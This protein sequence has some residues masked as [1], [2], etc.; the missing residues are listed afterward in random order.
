MSIAV[1]WTSFGPYH[2]ARLRAAAALAAR[3]GAK[4][5]GI[6][7]APRDAVYAWDAVGDN[8]DVA[9]TTLFPNRTYESLSRAEI[10]AAL[11]RTLDELEPDAVAVNGW[12]APEAQGA[13]AWS[14]RRCRA[15]VVMSETKADDM[16]R[17]WWKELAKRWLLGRCDAA[18]VGGAIHGDYL[19]EL[20]FPRERI[21]LGYDAVDNDYFRQRAAAVRARA[22]ELR[23]AAGLPPR[24]FFACTRFLARKNVDGLLRAYASY[25]RRAPAPTWGLVVAGSGEEAARLTGLERELALEGVI[26]RGFIQYDR[27]PL[28]Y[29]LA[30]AFVHAAKSEPWGLVVN[31]AIAS[32]LPVIVSLTTGARHDLVSDGENGYVFD[33]FDDD[34][35]AWALA[36]LAATSEADREA[37]GRRSLAIASRWGPERFAAG[38]IAAAR[39]G[40]RWDRARKAA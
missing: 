16:P 5:A 34:D 28:Y 17:I 35:L 1:I 38:L 39:M 6:E 20:G 19:T 26:W 13:I 3:E 23:E 32:G 12:S 11:F 24:F 31:E 29:G 9:R 21:V 10:A 7:I 37:M 40:K 18:L 8:D 25:R 30:S 36:R 4:I 15:A 27:L 22:A 2:V 33:P 14:D